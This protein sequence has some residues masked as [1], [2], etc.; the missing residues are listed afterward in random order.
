MA[1]LLAKVNG[2]PY[3]SEVPYQAPEAV[4]PATPIRDLTKAS[5]A[6]VTTGGLVPKGNPDGQAGVNA[7]KFFR[8]PITQLQRMAPG[9]WE[10][11]HV[12]YFT[13]IVDENPDYV[14]PL[15]LM[16][17]L[18]SAGVIGSVAPFAYTL[19]GV[20]TPVATSQALG[21]GIA[22]DLKRDNAGGCILVST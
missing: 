18:E 7:Q 19:P 16:R 2:R 9:D 3:A 11:F 17:E 14:L 1:M 20:G 10:A 13:H 21:L 15:G 6:L 5:I 22:E 8:Y 4:A 12:G